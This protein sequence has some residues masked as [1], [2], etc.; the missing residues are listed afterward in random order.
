MLLSAMW[1]YAITRSMRA[2]ANDMAKKFIISAAFGWVSTWVTTAWRLCGSR[3]VR[4]NP[5]CSQP[6]TNLG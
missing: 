2:F 4:R 6:T 1:V 5:E 3:L